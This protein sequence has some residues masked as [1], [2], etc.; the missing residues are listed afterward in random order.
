MRS[1]FA[2]RALRALFVIV[3]VA[4]CRATEP[5]VPTEA[6]ILESLPPAQADLLMEEKEAELARVA[7]A[8]AASQPLYD[9]LQAEW[10]AG[11]RIPVG[12]VPLLVCAPLAYGAAVAIIGPE[13]GELTVGP[14]RLTITPGAVTE[15]RVF[16]LERPV[17]M[18]VELRVS[19]HGAQFE[20]PV[21]LRLDHSQCN[22]PAALP[23]RVVHLDDRLAARGWP[24]SR[25]RR[26]VPQV[27]AD[28]E[29]FSRYAV[30]Y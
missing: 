2:P 12:G 10:T 24:P 27:E 23:E 30:A 5:R 29:H 9:S 16:V 7:A 18:L 8:E 26:N 22:R 4:G 3:V 6:E 11:R 14:N 28:L 20:R 19:P 1:P 25:E 21:V 17:S 13:G 15:P